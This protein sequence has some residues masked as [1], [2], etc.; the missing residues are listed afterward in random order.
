MDKSASLFAAAKK[1]I[2]GGVNS[3]VRAF[4]SVGSSPVFMAK[5]SGAYLYDVD[6]N[7]YIDYVGSW[8]P[9]VLGHNH[10]KVIESVKAA[11]DLG[12]SFGTATE[13]ETKLAL[14]VMDLMPKLSMLRFV[15]SGTEACMSALRLARGYTSRSKI[16]KFEGCYHGH[17]DCLLVKAGSGVA[18][19]SIPGSPGVPEGAIKD[20]LTAPFNDLAAAKKIVEEH[21]DDLAAIIVEPIVGNAGFIRPKEGFLEGL[22]SLCD[23]KKALLIFDEVMTGF[24]VAKGGAQEVFSDVA[25]DLVTLGKVIGGGMPIGAYGGRKEIMEQ[26]APSGPVYQAGTLSGNPVSVA[27]GLATLS[28]VEEADFGVLH[29]KSGALMKGLKEAAA[30]ADFSF[31]TDHQGGMFGFRFMAENPSDFAGAMKAD[32]ELFKRFFLSMLENG[33][34]L[35]PSAFEAGFISFAHSD[36]DISRTVEIAAGVFKKMRG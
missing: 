32:G 22:R 7:K 36:E 27:S 11:A 14:K 6:G 28:L 3:P 21:G 10:P 30:A 18:T 29:S 35:A 26:V 33:V 8:G 9:M 13:G 4:G 24:R 2:P 17:A 31:S 23:S 34:Y 19:L 20:T 25:C 5:A 16:L 15:S 12:L 1:V